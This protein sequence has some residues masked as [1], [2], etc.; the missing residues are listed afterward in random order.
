MH[1]LVDNWQLG[2]KNWVKDPF[3]VDKKYFKTFYVHPMSQWILWVYLLCAPLLFIFHSPVIIF[4]NFIQAVIVFSH[5]V[6][7]NECCT[8][9]CMRSC[10]KWSSRK[11]VFEGGQKWNLSL[12]FM[13]EIIWFWACI[14]GTSKTK[15]K[16][17]SYHLTES[18]TT[19]M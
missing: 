4:I 16:T 2:T 19:K 12:D 14:W 8:G 10:V 3:T 7:E 13:N 11:S 5:G 18:T 15:F 17:K 9:N 1:L 6:L